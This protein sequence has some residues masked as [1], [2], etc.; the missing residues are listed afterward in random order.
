M[1][2]TV[3]VFSVFTFIFG[4]VGENY[5]QQLKEIKMTVL[6]DNYVYQEGLETDWGFACFIEGIE[7]NIMFDT[8]TKPDL[9]IENLEKL[10]VNPG[11]ADWLVKFVG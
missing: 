11:D 8:G 10:K 7:K 2:K 6:Y 9:F 1:T 3:L 4:G 5:A